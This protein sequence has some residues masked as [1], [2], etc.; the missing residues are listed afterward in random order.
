MEPF[1]VHGQNI[2]LVPL[3][4]NDAADLTDALQDPVFHE[5]TS[6]P[7]PYTLSMA[8]ENLAKVPSKWEVL[9]GRFAA[10]M[11]DVSLGASSSFVILIFLTVMKSRTLFAMTSGERALQQR[12]CP[13]L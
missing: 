13:L 4:A 1:D 12:L 3:S 6:I 10:P 2:V 5:T 7:Y 8:E 11:M 9:I